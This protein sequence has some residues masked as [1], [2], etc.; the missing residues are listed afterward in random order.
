MYERTQGLQPAEDVL[1]SCSSVVFVQETRSP[2][3]GGSPNRS[4][5]TN[6]VNFNCFFRPSRKSS[7]RQSFRE[8]K[9]FRERNE[10]SGSDESLEPLTSGISG[11]AAIRR[12]SSNGPTRTP[13]PILRTLEE[14]A[15]K[16]RHSRGV[17]FSKMS[18]KTPKNTV[19]SRADLRKATPKKPPKTPTKD[20][21]G[22]N[23]KESDIEDFF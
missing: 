14:G 16:P 21:S 10:E 11:A 9:K 23:L 8:A 3:A 20:P 1:S 12:S 22:H 17:S 6:A 19:Y 15:A 5:L 18:P 7:S 4:V 2:F 13:K